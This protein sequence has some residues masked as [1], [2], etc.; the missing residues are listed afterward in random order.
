[1]SIDSLQGT[2]REFALEMGAILRCPACTGVTLRIAVTRHGCFL[3][4]RGAEVVHFA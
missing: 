2:R 3:D 1:M 4:M